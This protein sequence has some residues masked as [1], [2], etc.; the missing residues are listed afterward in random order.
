[1]AAIKACVK[2]DSEASRYYR[3]LDKPKEATAEVTAEES[4]SSVKSY[5]SRLSEILHGIEEG[6]GGG[7]RS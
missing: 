1:M 6:A 7:A 2:V 3:K 4:S 5:K